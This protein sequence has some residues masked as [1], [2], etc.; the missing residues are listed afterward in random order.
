MNK[1]FKYYFLLL[2][3][4]GYKIIL[5][6]SV[7]PH[8]NPDDDSTH[9]IKIRQA[10]GTIEY[11]KHGLLINID[12]THRGENFDIAE[13]FENNDS[14]KNIRYSLKNAPIFEYGI[15]KTDKV[16]IDWGNYHFEKESYKKAISRFSEVNNKSL[17]V[18]RKL[19][20]SYFN[21]SSLDLSLIHI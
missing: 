17:D 21:I 13:N 15:G 16:A 9:V 14:L 8:F 3:L 7:E 6:Q 4:L 1:Y 20:R 11:F 12:S 5:S 19:G 18:L 10:D 2:T